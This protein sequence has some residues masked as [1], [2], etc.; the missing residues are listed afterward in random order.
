MA[1][2]KKKPEVVP[3]WHPNFRVVDALPDIKQVR[4]G[5]IVNF[6]TVTLAVL[7]LGWTVVTEVEIHKVNTDLDHFNTNIAALTPTTTKDLASSARFVSTSKPLQFAAKFFSEKLS[8]LDVYSSLMDARPSDILFDSLE[9]D[10]VVLDLGGTK[11][12]YTQRIIIDGTLSSNNLLSLD[13]FVTKAQ[14]SP[15]FKSRI[16]GDPK[17]RKIETH[18]DQAAGIFTFTVTITL[19]PPV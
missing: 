6:I 14:N 12:A 5:F 15:A 17:D 11:K 4:T 7:A 13:E 3:F 16:T 2:G 18:G 19:K 1:I 8:P 9:I 10:S